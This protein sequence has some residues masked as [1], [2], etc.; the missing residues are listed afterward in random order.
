MAANLVDLLVPGLGSSIQLAVGL[1][2]K[3]YAKYS[4]L[5][6]GKELCTKLHARLEAFIRELINIDDATLHKEDI[7]SRLV[8]LVGEC[9][10][11]VVSY[12]YE[13]KFVKRVM[14]ATTFTEEIQVYNERLDS[15][16]TLICVKQT[17]TLV[18]WRAQY[19]R[20]A[21]TMMEQICIL[22]LLKRNYHEATEC[23][24]LDP[25]LHNIVNIGKMVIDKEVATPS[26]W[27]IGAD[28]C[29]VHDPPIDK[30]GQSQIF[31]GKW[32]GVQVAIKKF[33]VMTKSPVFDKHSKV[34]RS[35]LHPHVAQLYGVGSDNGA[36]FFVYEYASR[37]SLDRC[38]SNLSLKELWGMLYQA[39]LGLSYLHTRHIVHGNL[40]CSKLLVTGQGKVKLFG[41]GGS[42]VRENSQTQRH[43]WSLEHPNTMGLDL[44]EMMPELS[45]VPISRPTCTRSV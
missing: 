22:L 27:L 13:A 37:Q 33:R 26:S 3:L 6:E 14:R 1:L 8:A 11:T 20:D 34:W 28:E 38:W 19:E 24:P 15:I 10:R 2:Q 29:E 32:Q 36:P 4:E 9:S 40:S 16:M 41:F 12:R 39:A 44:T 43:E 42:Y 31:I 25:V 7:L 35:L 5:K 30:K 17:V 21:A 18:E 45:T 23:S